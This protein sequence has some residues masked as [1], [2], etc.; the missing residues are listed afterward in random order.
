METR[1]MTARGCGGGGAWDGNGSAYKRAPRA[2]DPCDD[3]KVLQLDWIKHLQHPGCGAGQAQSLEVSA[4]HQVHRAYS[5]DFTPGKLP[6]ETNNSPLC[7]STW[8]NVLDIG[9]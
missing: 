1:L 7:S 4:R 5:Q 3:G 2:G 9:Q 8:H 6:L